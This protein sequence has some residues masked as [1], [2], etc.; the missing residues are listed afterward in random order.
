MEQEAE[1]TRPSVEE[2]QRSAPAGEYEGGTRA[3]AAA[4]TTTLELQA[5]AASLTTVGE[6]PAVEKAAPGT[7]EN[8]S[9]WEPVS[10]TA[11]AGDQDS[12]GSPADK[13]SPSLPVAVVSAVASSMASATLQRGVDTH[14]ATQAECAAKKTLQDSDACGTHIDCAPAGGGVQSEV[15]L[16]EDRAFDLAAT[17]AA[18]KT[19]RSGASV[20]AVQPAPNGSLGKRTRRPTAKLLARPDD[21]SDDKSSGVGVAAVGEGSPK[22][23]ATMPSA[24]AVIKGSPESDGLTPLPGKQ[25][26]VWKNG[27]WQ[28]LTTEGVAVI[29]EKRFPDNDAAGIPENSNGEGAARNS[30]DDCKVVR[31]KRTMPQRE[32]DDRGRNDANTAGLASVTVQR[33]LTKQGSKPSETSVPEALHQNPS[34]TAAQWKMTKK[35]GC[36]ASCQVLE[37]IYSTVIVYD[38]H[39]DVSLRLDDNAISYV[40]GKVAPKSLCKASWTV[41]ETGSFESPSKWSNADRTKALV[42]DLMG[43]RKPKKWREEKDDEQFCSFDEVE[44]KTFLRSSTQAN[45]MH[46][47]FCLDT[48]QTSSCDVPALGLTSG[49]CD[50]VDML[51]KLESFKWKKMADGKWAGD[52]AHPQSWIATG[53]QANKL[54]FSAL[55][56]ESAHNSKENDVQRAVAHR[57]IGSGCKE[58]GRRSDPRRSHHK[59]VLHA[60]TD[61]KIVRSQPKVK[62]LGV[63]QASGAGADVSSSEIQRSHN[64]ADVSSDEI[65]RSHKKK[66]PL[67]DG[68]RDGSLKTSKTL[69]NGDVAR[70]AKKKARKEKEEETRVLA[71]KLADKGLCTVEI[72]ADGHC[73][74]SAVGDQLKRTG[75]QEEYS[76]KTLRHAAANYMRQ[77]EDHFK[78]FLAIDSSDKS[79]EAYCRRIEKTN[80]WGGQHEL[81]ALSHVLKRNIQVL[82]HDMS[83]QT[84]PDPETHP[85][86][87]GDPLRLSYHIHEY[88]GGE[89]YNSVVT[90]E[91]KNRRVRAH[92]ERRADEEGAAAKSGQASDAEPATSGSTASSA[93]H[94]A[95]IKKGFGFGAEGPK[96]WVPGV[97]GSDYRV[98]VWD[99]RTGK[100]SL[101]N[102]CPIAKNIERY[103][104]E[105]PHMKVWQGGID[106]EPV[107]KPTAKHANMLAT[108]TSDKTSAS[109]VV[110]GGTIVENGESQEEGR[111]M[112]AAEEDEEANR[113]KVGCGDGLDQGC[114]TMAGD[115]REKDGTGAATSRGGELASDVFDTTFDATGVI[116]RRETGDAD[117]AA[118]TALTAVAADVVTQDETDAE[119]LATEAG[120]VAAC[121]AAAAQHQLM[122]LPVN[123]SPA[124]PA[125]KHVSTL[126]EAG[127]SAARQ[128]LT[129]LPAIETSSDDALAA[130]VAQA[131]S[132]RCE[133]PTQTAQHVLSEVGGQEEVASL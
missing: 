30:T 119:T 125:D 111:V 75:C 131:S 2:S 41:L 100:L 13:A 47:Y 20:T 35:V 118:G 28:R 5:V 115:E 81:I 88:S 132:N 114:I 44:A 23:Q 104:E 91:E 110:V 89:H 3:A 51:E 78:G 63:S 101:G 11:G 72:P 84:F 123:A 67:D 58:A 40:R 117:A 53:V 62:L 77:N 29:S 80:A 79:F 10:I 97:G 73:L 24:G 45:G 57:R 66:R 120:K 52:D 83:V 21:T 130:E 12:A 122:Q 105:R 86:Y 48:T 33:R 54:S 94:A 8:A 15:G 55:G 19:Q 82:R 109:T 37:Q 70:T 31:P 6:S 14:N 74:F 113:D 7:A 108:G 85:P 99:T 59:S 38:C 116:Q 61:K 112:V 64:Q 106:G 56:L 22:R 69:S 43:G 102:S 95:A 4:T 26:R 127:A 98:P 1:D 39:R 124:V 133:K 17:S 71:K 50:G 103:L 34:E 92:R 68:A 32:H 27:R 121:V 126:P 107:W 25:K 60:T 9:P 93:Q 96:P 49:G 90:V 129:V 36:I 42:A 76:Y 87:D 46:R 16:S 65:Q 18:E 128:P